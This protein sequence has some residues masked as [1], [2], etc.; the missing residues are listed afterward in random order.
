MTTYRAFE[1]FGHVPWKYGMH[2]GSILGQLGFYEFTRRTENGKI[3][4]R[5]MGF[6]DLMIPHVAKN[7]GPD[8]FTLPGDFEYSL[9]DRMFLEMH[10]GPDGEWA[11]IRFEVPT[12]AIYKYS[13]TI[14]SLKKNPINPCVVLIHTH[15]GASSILMNEQLNTNGNGS[16][17]SAPESAKA[18]EAVPGDQIDLL[19]G[20]GYRRDVRGV[21]AGAFICIEH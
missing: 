12:A 6:S 9:P 1:E 10:P 18:I 7:H 21:I 5:D 16:E 17:I 11:I 20:F 4:T 8:D 2:K 13:A 14:K 15:K 19:V 3:E